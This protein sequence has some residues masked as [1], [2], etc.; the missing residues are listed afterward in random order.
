MITIHQIKTYALSNFHF[1]RML[2]KLQEKH[3]QY[4]QAILDGMQDES[5]TS[6][7]KSWSRLHPSQKCSD[8][9]GR[10]IPELISNYISSRKGGAK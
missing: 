9:W 4:C 6:M 8:K 3:W 5:E 7:N 1:A 2:P 10:V